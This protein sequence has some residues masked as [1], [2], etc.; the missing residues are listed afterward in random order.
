MNNCN[1][2]D[3]TFMNLVQDKTK[4]LNNGFKIYNSSFSNT[5]LF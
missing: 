2:I 1:L 3:S 5:K 4:I